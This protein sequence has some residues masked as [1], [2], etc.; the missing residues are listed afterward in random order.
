MDARDQHPGQDSPAWAA[1]AP[2]ACVI[3]GGR[4]LRTLRAAGGPQTYCL[5]C[6]HAWRPDFPDYPYAE[7]PMCSHG[8]PRERYEQQVRFFAP[9]AGSAPRILEL[10]CATGELAHVARQILPVARYDG[11]EMSPAR[12]QARPHLDA[13]HTEPLSVL[14]ENGFQGEYD[15]VAMSHVLEHLRDPAVELRAMKQVLAPGGAIFLEVPN[16]SGHPRLPIDD[17]LC[18]LHFFSP[19]SLT[20][21]LANEGLESAA[22]ATGVRLDARCTDALQVIGRRF[23]MPDWSPSF[24]SDRPAFEGEREIVVWGAGGLSQVLLANYFDPACIAFFVD[25]DPKK[26]GQ[27]CLGRPILAPEALGDRPRT[28]LVNSV[29][30]ARSIAADIDRVAAGARHRVIFLADL[31]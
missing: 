8:L 27:Q 29:D 1:P 30:F 26:Q 10:G 18:H 11:V 31:L 21:L 20:R 17:N 19:S 9:F 23:V 7:T 6:F 5:A 13:L 3:C 25:R 16:R 12:E 15:V 24:L 14:I 4:D 22:V 28:I 2:T